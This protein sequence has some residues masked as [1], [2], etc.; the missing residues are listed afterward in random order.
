VV[1]HGAIAAGGVVSPANATYTAEELLYQLK[2]SKSKYLVTSPENLKPA[3]EAAKSAG[4]SK[5]NIFLFGDKAIDGIRPYTHVIMAD[6]EAPG[7]EYTF[8]E[9]KATTAYLCFSS[10]TTGRSKGVM[11]RYEKFCS[12]PTYGK[13]IPYNSCFK[14]FEHIL[15]LYSNYSGLEAANR[16]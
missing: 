2:E 1:A 5:E 7:E 8:E 6:H 3:L 16:P 15:Q 10:G 12:L 13:H 4:I 14:S 11:T 9:A